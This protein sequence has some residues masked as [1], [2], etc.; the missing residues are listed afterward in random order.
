MGERATLPERRLT[1]QDVDRVPTQ[2]YRHFGKDGELLYVGVSLSAVARLS[3]H[4]AVSPW[5]RDIVRVDVEIFPTR[6]EAL[7]AEK[8][9]IQTENPLHNKAMK[10]KDVRLA[11]IKGQPRSDLAQM[12]RDEWIERI[13][14]F[15]ICYD[16]KSA[17]HALN[18]TASAI[19]RLIAAG[20]IGHFLVP[21]STGTKMLVRISGWHLIEYMEAMTKYG[22]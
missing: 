20:T 10:P 7:L 4:G 14:R 5:F 21:N 22:Q 11:E 12:S 15:G 17:A 2:L 19:R 9:A 16:E 8:R 13:V 1:A 6:A 3:A 18:V